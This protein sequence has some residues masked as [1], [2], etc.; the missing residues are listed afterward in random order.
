M[1]HQREDDLALPERQARVWVRRLTSGTARTGDARALERWCRASE[2]NR[3]A[4]TAAHRQWQAVRGAAE[5]AGANDPELMALRTA[6]RPQARLAGAASRRRFL[7]GGVALASAAAVGVLVVHPPLALW[8]SLESLQADYTTGVGEQRKLALGD[9]VTVEL[10]TR[11]SL[12]V[13]SDGGRPV[14]VDLIDGQVA[15]DIGA[16]AGPFTVFA[17]AGS[18]Q[19]MDA[20]FEVRHVAGGICVTCVDGLVQVAVAGK[21]VNLV[22]EQQVTYGQGILQPVRRVNAAVL[23]AWR[24]GLLS[25]QR[26]ALAQVVDEINRYRPGRVILLSRQFEGRPVSGQ[27]Y[28]RDLDKA[29]TQIQRLFKLEVTSLPGG[30]VLLS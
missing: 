25:F 22:A 19:A 16:K 29:I 10:S 9:A 14:G 13:R 24:D 12:S 23:T 18:V 1:K 7:A 15:V 26:T 4:F 5:L 27:F 30:I 6:P 17:A 8:P 21:R 3:R 2:A 20:S 11:S 28:I